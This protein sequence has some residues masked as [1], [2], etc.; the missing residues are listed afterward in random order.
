MRS[1]VTS[2]ANSN[3]SNLILSSVN[4]RNISYKMET[5]YEGTKDCNH[6]EVDI[7]TNGECTC[8]AVTTSERCDCYA[9]YE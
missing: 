2:P 9:D 1:F 8:N 5:P 6:H 3:V 4:I 7:K